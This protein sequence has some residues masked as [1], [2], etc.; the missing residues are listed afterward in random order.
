MTIKLH[1]FPL[2]PRAFKVL[3]AAEQFGVPYELVTI[4]FGRGDTRT[5]AYTAMNPNQRMPTMDHDGFYLW[6]SNAI[7]NYLAEQNPDG[8]Y[9][10]KDLKARALTQ[11]WQFWESNHWDPA[12]AIFMFER[13]VKKLF[14]RGEADPAELKKGADLMARL[15][16]VLDGQLAKTRF[17]VGDRL[18]AAD[19]ALGGT[20]VGTEQA[21]MPLEDYRGIQRWLTELRALP[22]WQKAA[23]LMKPP[24]A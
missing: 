13:V 23:A 11:Q 3:F 6:E 18:T 2:S 8:G 22:G 9:L 24:G 15:A 12:A 7:V 4:D 1:G 14:G 21:G 5:P 20:L 16:P 19:V 10:P 17:V